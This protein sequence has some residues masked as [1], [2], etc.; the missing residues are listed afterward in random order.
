V[1]WTA[2]KHRVLRHLMGEFAEKF[3]ETT[4]SYWGAA[5][6]YVGIL[7]PDHGREKRDETV[8]IPLCWWL[9]KAGVKPHPGLR[10]FIQEFKEREG[11]AAF[12]RRFGDGTV[13]SIA[14]RLYQ[15]AKEAHF[16]AAEDSLFDSLFD[17]IEAPG[18]YELAAEALRRFNDPAEV[19]RWERRVDKSLLFK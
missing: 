1:T 6:V 16:L 2:K 9:K 4:P 3:P 17:A 18:S 11:R 13:D 15:K 7:M 14:R 12:R 10:W 5:M 8:L 19:E